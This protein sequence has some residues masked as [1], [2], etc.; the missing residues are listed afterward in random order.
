MGTPRSRGP[1][2]PTGYRSHANLSSPQVP[3][4]K[5]SDALFRRMDANLDGKLSLQEVVAGADL[6]G[7]LPA[8]AAAFF[9]RLDA[10]GDGFVR[11]LYHCI[12]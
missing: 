10:N 11:S 9:Q 5:A 8:E 2:P 7:M 4:A 12:W 1:C 6:L 3:S